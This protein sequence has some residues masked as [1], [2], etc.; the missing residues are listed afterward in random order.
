MGTIKPEFTPE[1]PNCL[2]EDENKNRIKAYIDDQ[3]GAVWMFWPSGATTPFS[4][5]WSSSFWSGCK[6][7]PVVL[8]D[9]SGHGNHAVQCATDDEILDESFTIE[10]LF[11]GG[12]S[13][14]YTDADGITHFFPKEDAVKKPSHYG[15]G[16]IE[17]IDYIRDFLTEEEYIGYLRGN[18]AKYLH[19]WRYKN[20]LE[21]LKKAQVYLGWMI[22]T[23]EK[24]GSDE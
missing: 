3:I 2:I 10:S 23:V 12:D 7:L 1:E 13:G 19:R 18:V 15:Q 8:K 22:E 20:G 14:F 17:C 16:S 6:R 11:E 4:R 5:P 21:D 9:T 24:G